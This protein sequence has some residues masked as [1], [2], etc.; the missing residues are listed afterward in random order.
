MKD[1]M[2]EVKIAFALKK[3]RSKERVV[4]IVAASEHRLKRTNLFITEP[5]YVGKAAKLLH[6][7]KR[8]HL[9]GRETPIP[10]PS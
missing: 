10:L 8:G 3:R 9:V 4:D 1:V 7:R 6:G 2:V 5:G